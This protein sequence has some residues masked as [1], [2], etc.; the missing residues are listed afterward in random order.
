MKSE[1]MQVAS[2]EVES[3]HEYEAHVIGR[4]GDLGLGNPSGIPSEYAN[5]SDNELQEVA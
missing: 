3:N 2:E 5:Y 4:L 1:Q